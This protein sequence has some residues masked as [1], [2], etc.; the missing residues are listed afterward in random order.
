MEENEI[1]L[2]FLEEPEIDLS[3][4]EEEKKEDIDLSF[5]EEDIDLSFLAE[6]EKEDIDLSFL[7]EEKEE[8]KMP[9]LGDIGKGLGAEIAIGESAKLT[10]TTAGAFVGGPIGAAIGYLVGGISGGITGSLAAQRIEGKDKY[11]WGRVAADTLLNIIPFAGGKAAKTTKLFPKLGKRALT[12]AGISAGAAQIEK[13]IEEGE[14]LS[15]IELLAA[16]ATGGAL[17]IGIGAAS[18]A[19]GDIY[20]RK[21]SGK[22]VDEIQKKYDEG[23]ADIVA[24]ID[25][26]TKEGD[27]TGRFDR[28]KKSVST[29]ILPSKI[30]GNKAS[31]QIRESMSKAEAAMD[32]GTRARKQIDDVYK[33]LDADGKKAVDD[34]LLGKTSDISLVKYRTL[35]EVPDFRSDIPNENWLKGYQEDADLDRN[36]MG[37]PDLI[38]TTGSF[39]GEK[40]TLQLPIY[41]TKN[42]KG[43]LGEE[44]RLNKEKVDRL[45]KEL[46]KD[47]KFQE[48]P[49]IGVAFDGTPYIVEGNHRIAASQK[50]GIPID[51]EVR[52]FDGGERVAKQGFKPQELLSE[53]TTGLREVK[54]V[55]DSARRKLDEYQDTVIDL[56]D[57]GVLDMNELTYRKIIES[58]QRGD[59]LTTEYRFFVDDDYMPTKEQTDA[60]MARLTEDLGSERAAAD[61]IRRLLDLKDD[62]EAINDILKQKEIQT[63]EMQDYLGLITDPGERFFGT[64]KKLGK[65]AA[66]KDG[67]NKL[68]QRFVSSGVG[69]VADSEAD[70]ARLTDSGFVPLRIRGK[71]QDKFGRRRVDGE[72]KGGQQ[73]YVPREVNQA[74]DLLSRKTFKEDSTLW[75]ENLATQLMGTT[76]ALTKFAK[77][78]LSVAAYPVQV[79]GNMAMVATM[80]MN[81]FKNYSKNFRVALS[82]L[83]SGIF[84]E[85]KIAKTLTM[86]RM[87]RLKE[88]N[89]IDKGIQAGEIREGFNKGF[90]GK[91]MG[92]ITE[93]V[94]KAYSTFD[95]AQRITVFDHYKNILKASM[96]ETDLQKL[97]GFDGKRFEEIAAELT[98]A[99]YQNYDRINPAIRYFSRIGVLNE[100]VSFNL[101][102][103]RTLFNQGTLIRNLKNGKFAQDMKDEFDV[104]LD[105][106]FLNDL[107]NKRLASGLAMLA[108]ATAGITLAN[109]GIQG[110]TQ[111]EERAIRETVVPYWDEDSKLL[112]K[113]DGDK[114][115]TANM[116]YQLPIAELTSVFESGLRGEDAYESIGNVFRSAWSKMGGS[117]TINANNFFAAINNRDP[118]TGR[119]I[120]DEPSGARQ[121][122]DRLLYYT[123]K[124]FTPTLLGK[125]SDKTTPDLIARYTLGL[126]NQNTTVE[127]GAGFKLRALKDNIN[128][129]RR[130]YSSDFY[131]DKDMQASYQDRNNTYRRNIAEVIKHVNNLR[132]LGKTDEEINKIM[133]KNGLSKSVRESAL[134][135]EMEDMPLAVGI[136]GSRAERKEKLL[137]IYDKLPPEIGLLMLNEAKEDGKIKQSTI[138]E[139]IRQSQ[140]NKLNP[141]L[142]ALQ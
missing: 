16:G 140:L 33:T 57:R 1:D 30:I 11:S 78:P 31:A 105:Q 18:D 130:S 13:G 46:E 19:L 52:Y 135:G 49:L 5:L 87:N 44:T 103:L 9:S 85:G 117:G 51:I 106:N 80:G 81:P 136:S 127:D 21:I 91:K 29:Y 118:R 79:F 38:K 97:G 58:R 84:K 62:P 131:Q 14:F 53:S 36:R 43:Y 128:N 47:G 70:I 40:K 60:L 137:Q 25:A 141:D 23:D 8:E 107:A 27:P 17:N 139:V 122:S 88:L 114:V 12:G 95:T 45:S 71:L 77:V 133:S 15:P 39:R 4:L 110:V 119:P 98:N 113:K 61:K 65:L 41:K 99:T 73:V 125:T 26:V 28:F 126:R 64:L 124:S 116:S 69:F 142:S 66:R 120:S 94:G 121:F 56:Y 24:L 96:N 20:R 115:K 90:F 74:V 112:I 48:P 34:Y 22:N 7:A 32:L 6:E 50:L 3:F 59:Y 76:T 89:L 35:E 109:R 2:S 37:Y 138:N 129:V 134:R 54:T 63:K 101:E 68:T 86:E 132:I 104:N 67:D 92:Q 10:G 100:F 82:D 93:P 42:I 72:L 83:N 108:T 55:I 75:S 123:T 102:Q 111:D